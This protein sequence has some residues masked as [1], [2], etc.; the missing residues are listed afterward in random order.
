MT[1]YSAKLDPKIRASLGD[2]RSDFVEQA[3]VRFVHLKDAL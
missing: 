1:K 2:L 3:F